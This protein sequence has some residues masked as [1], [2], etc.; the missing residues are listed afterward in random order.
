MISLDGHQESGIPTA[1]Q[2]E[3]DPLPALS[4]RFIREEQVD[5]LYQHILDTAMILMHA[6]MSSLQLLQPERGNLRMIGWKGSTA[7]PAAFLDCVRASADSR[8][9]VAVRT[10]SRIL[11][12]DIEAEE[13]RATA[14]E[15]AAFS[16][17]GVRAMQ[18]TPLVSLSGRS[19]GVIS[20]YWCKPGLPQQSAWRMLDVLARQA[21]DLIERAQSDARLRETA[22]QKDALYELANRL[23]RTR[24][25]D[26]VYDAALTAIVVALQCDRASIL[27]FDD[28]GAMRFVAS[29]GLSDNYRDAVEGHSAWKPT[30]PNPAPIHI[31]D[32]SVAAMNESLRASIQAEGIGALAFIPLV[33]DGQLIGKFMAYFNGPHAFSQDEMNLCLTIA[34]QVA[35][36]IERKRAEDRLR[37]SEQRFRDMIDALP[38]AIYMTDA[39]GRVVHFNRAAVELSGRTPQPGVDQWCICEKLYEA[40][41]AA[42]AL[43]ESIMA[44]V[45]RGDA[46]ERG[47]ALIAERPDGVRR[48]VI[49][50]PTL[51]RDESGRVSGGVNMLVDITERKEAEEALREADRRKDEFLA[52]LSHELRN[53]LAPIAIA[54][55]ILNRNPS[56]DPVQRQA[57]D[58][59]DRQTA[60]LTRLVDDLLEVSRITSGRI[61]LQMKRVALRDVVDRAIE[62]VRAA[63]SAHRHTLQVSLPLESVW[64]HAD[65]ARIEQVVINLLNNAAKYTDDGGRIQLI[66]E[67]EKTQAI[68]RVIDNGM[69]IEPDLLPRIF[70]LFTQARRSLARSQGGLGIG[71]SLVQ[72]LVTMHGGTVT[73]SSTV[74]R[75][76]EFIVRLPVQQVSTISEA[77]LA[78]AAPGAAA[79]ALRVLIVDDNVDAARSLGL[80]LESWKHSV[81]LA[82]DGLSALEVVSE[83]RPH[84]V[85]L[86]I[87]L[88]SI[89]G[90]EVARRLRDEY[91]RDD[92]TLVALTGYGL[93][94][95]RERAEQAGFDLHLVKPADIAAVMRCLSATS[96]AVASHAAL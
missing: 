2:P 87:G 40:D 64:L 63:I 28:A 13:A 21:A 58:I 93:R 68:L 5:A 52:M 57:R 4:T 96:A 14:A 46:V 54:V 38:A 61:Q 6:D 59:I 42:V 56:D 7:T 84:V 77:D 80:L 31:D 49:P 35:F 37:A 16:A 94:S 79:Q 74:G 3:A 73:A 78:T 12:A 30:D 9:A 83:I 81:A 36:A 60:S 92:L 91:P 24:S 65:A 72:R 25:L 75:G 19:L 95:D 85:F 10:G 82:H 20:T 71:L 8:D 66:V 86:D 90:Y 23:H 47:T 69:G 34:R 27:L 1:G 39:E 32:V 43:E 41:G 15:I 89:D 26:E 67:L 17:A 51:L 22:R 70:D 88:P 44:R 29:G 48:W 62:S 11:V 55:Q 50:Y 18:T 45:F 33:S 53:P 76:S